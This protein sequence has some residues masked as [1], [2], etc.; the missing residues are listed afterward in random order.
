MDPKQIVHLSGPSS[1]VASLEVRSKI[2]KNSTKKNFRILYFVRT[3]QA[4][5]PPNIGYTTAL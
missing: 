3:Y 5:V 2:L 4:R 1:S